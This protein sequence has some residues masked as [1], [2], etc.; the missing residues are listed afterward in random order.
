MHV[1]TNAFLLLGVIGKEGVIREYYGRV[2]VNTQCD[3][4]WYLPTVLAALPAC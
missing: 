2:L 1:L 3:V 4:S